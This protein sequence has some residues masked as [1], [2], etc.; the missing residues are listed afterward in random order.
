LYREKGDVKASIIIPVFNKADLTR[1]CI[2]RLIKTTSPDLRCEI[3]IID[4]ASTDD[5]DSMLGAYKDNV[6]VIRNKENAGFTIACNQG[7]QAASGEFLVILNNDVLVQDDWLQWIVETAE[8]DNSIGA[9]GAK[10][11]FPDGTLQEA[12]GIIWNDAS[13][14]NYGRTDDPNHPKYNYVRKVDY[15][16]GAC[17]LVRRNVFH[18]VGGF[19]ARYAPAYYEDADLCFAVRKVGKKVVYQPRAEVIHLEGQTAGT[20]IKQGIKRY[21]EINK[22][23]FYEKWEHELGSQ[24]PPNVSYA[25]S[26]CAR[27]YKKNILIV[28]PTMPAYDISAGDQR[29]FKII[30]ILTTLDARI[31]FVS[32]LGHVNNR[33][34]YVLELEQMGVEVY[35]SDPKRFPQ[36]QADK[37][38]PYPMDIES[39]LASRKYDIALLSHYDYAMRYIDEIRHL[40]PL[41]KIYLDT[42]DVH[43]LREQRMAEIFNNKDM[44]NEA[45]NVKEQELATC[46]KSDVVITVTSEEKNVLLRDVPDLN[47]KILGTIHDV[48]K[49]SPPFEKR[50][51]LLFIGNFGHKP[52]VDAILFFVKEVFPIVKDRITDIKLYVVGNRPTEEINALNSEDV[53]VT[54]F[55]PD[56]HPYLDQC[57]VSIAPLRYGA[58]MKGKVGEAMQSGVPVVLTTVAAEGMDL[59]DRVEVLIADKPEDFAGAIEQLYMDKTL[60]DQLVANAK[61]KVEDTWSS[62]A[63]KGEVVRIFEIS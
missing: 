31:T 5:T 63:V 29:L 59:N 3:I 39:I 42:V 15:C 16:S 24:F 21:Q 19:D 50:K 51:D 53:I 52:N 43:Y 35:R 30:S 40:S 61:K 49:N 11:I 41:T 38:D 57:K 25:D 18:E 2:D 62:K 28:H 34:V 10:L 60:W 36:P 9:V 46:S 23:K 58:G 14:A 26:A 48:V 45:M 8:R 27:D 1:S 33:L 55:V 44:M 56:T 13:G 4:N 54:G 22:Q 47:V 7:A 20:D 12:G 17:L 6:A 32:S 37:Q